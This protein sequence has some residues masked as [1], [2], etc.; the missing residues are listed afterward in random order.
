MPE[1]EKRA[2]PITC[3]VTPPVQP[4]G[5]APESSL[6]I[7]RSQTKFNDDI[8][9]VILAAASASTAVSLDG[10]PE[11]RVQEFIE[12]FFP[13]ASDDEL[14]APLPKLGLVLLLAESFLHANFRDFFTSVRLISRPAN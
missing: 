14:T 6:A 5:D 11:E 9:S 2:H 13:S 1:I 4:C 12:P 7:I 3:H 8:E 10:I